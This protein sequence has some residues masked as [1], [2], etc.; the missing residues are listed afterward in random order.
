[1]STKRIGYLDGVKFIAMLLCIQEHLIQNGSYHA[2]AEEWT[3][4]PMFLFIYSFHMQLFLFISGMFFGNNAKLTTP[5]LLKG[6]FS[7]S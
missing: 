5:S 1:M 7:S 3:A 4:D 6:S 2:S